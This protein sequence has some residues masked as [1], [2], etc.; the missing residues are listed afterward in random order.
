MATANDVLRIAAGEI[1]Y[2][3]W[4]DPQQGTKYGRWY[5]Q[6][7]GDSY[8]GQ[9]GVPYCAMFVSWVFDQAGQSVPG[10]PGAYCPYIKRDG[11]NAG[12]RVNKY[13]AKP[14]DIVLFDWGGDGV[15][16][17]VGVVEVNRGSY[18]QTLEGNT[19]TGTSGS[20]GNGGV[21]ARRTRSF[22]T[23]NTILRPQYGVSQNSQPA[24]V[25]TD[26]K[27][28]V[29]G[30]WGKATNAKIQSLLGTPVDGI[31]SH[32]PTSNKQ[33]LAS[34]V[35]TGAW[36]FTNSYG[37]GSQM[38]IELQRR[39]GVTAD[40]WFGPE[41]IKALQTVMGT[42]VDGT[43]DEGSSCVMELQRRLS[44]DPANFLKSAQPAQV[45]SNPTP[46]PSTTTLKIAE[47]GQWGEATNRELQTQLGTTADG[48]ISSQYSGNRQFY[49]GVTGGW[50]WVNNAQGS[51]CIQKLQQLIGTDVDGVAGQGTARALQTWLSNHGYPIGN[52]GVDGYIGADSVKGLQ[53]CLNDGLIGS[54]V[55]GETKE[56]PAQNVTPSSSGNYHSPLRGIDVSSHDNFNGSVFK[57]NTESAYQGSD[58]VIV[59]VSQGIGYVN[60]Q[61][62]GAYQ[63]SKRDGK[64]LGFY[65]YAGGNDPSQE[66]QYFYDNA[67]GY[68][69]EGIP[70]IDWESNQNKAWG[71]R[72]WVRTFCNKVHDLS[73]VWPMIYVQASAINQ[74]SNCADVCPLW[75][76]GYP[77]N[78][79]NWNFPTFRYNISPW[80]AYTLWQY[81]SSNEQTDRDVANVSADGWHKIAQG[82]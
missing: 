25:S 16:D 81:S 60:P 4:T 7:T 33:Y 2:S 36:E 37:G 71:N 61:C 13:Q 27:L 42:T 43:L 58:F 22:G 9:S 56:S 19:S 44:D 35:A 51:Q 69:K 48:V 54:L 26:G 12:L 78:R 53:I 50:E 82:S 40:G 24:P 75:V 17:H 55:S 21:V 70:V 79:N 15:P 30:Y 52:S 18:L 59:K 77:D 23:I 73:G 10:L 6:K 29:D 63:R 34:C 14:G 80:S 74:V 28:D 3:R 66:A 20:Q 76:A 45:N 41:S 67:R 57:S 46:A 49:P 11:I 38:I 32:Q 31:V 72:N 39:L 65:H 47:D 64:L 68:F 5:A 1:G 62:D 8:Y